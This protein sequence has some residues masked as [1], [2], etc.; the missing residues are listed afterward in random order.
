MKLRAELE[1]KIDVAEQLFPELMRLISLY[2]DG[3]DNEDRQKV[4]SA[5]KQMNLLTNK[6]IN[7]EDLFEYWEA[8]SQEELA[9]KLSLPEPV[10]AGNISKEEL[11]EIIERI[12]S[13]DDDGI[14]E[15]LS[16][17][18]VPLSSILAEAYYLP[19]LERNFS[20]PEPYD[21]FERQKINGEYIE[22]TADEIAEKI[23]SH[24]PLEL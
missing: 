9:F 7:E 16:D 8:E 12:Q 10:K 23:L 6:D 17:A 21:L 1:P 4:E 5:I 3:Y 14:S 22:F 24:K 11:L 13:F 2:D 20:Y 19:L 15:V 18:N